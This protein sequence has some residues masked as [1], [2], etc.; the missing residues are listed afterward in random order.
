MLNIFKNQFKILL[1][2]KSL[3]F[4]S[5]IFPLILGTLF[6]LAFSNMEE[7]EKFSKI[8]IAVV[9][10]GSFLD[11]VNS[12][13]D[14][15][16]VKEVSKEEAEEMLLDNDITGYYE[17]K[18]EI[19]IYV[20]G[21][22]TSST[23]M[24]Y[25]VDNYYVYSSVGMSVYENTG[26]LISGIESNNYF[27]DSSNDKVDFTVI[28]FYTLIGM[29]C[30]LAGSFGIYAVTLSEANLS[31]KGARLSVSPTNKLKALLITLITV[32]IVQYIEILIIYFY[33]IVILGIKFSYI[34]H[35]L[36]LTLV[37]CIAG[38]S[39]GAFIGVSN[40]KDENGKNGILTAV[41]MTASFLS[42]MMSFQV[43]HL[44]E[45]SMPLLAKINPV[46]M[47][48]DGLLSLYYAN[49]DRF[50]YNLYSLV[51]FSLIFIS[52]SY[53]FIRRKK[54]DSI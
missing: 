43:K 42:G 34:Y 47:I 11:V 9:G 13:D 53:F 10:D 22:S 1:R 51:L 36:L 26:K 5:L 32:F 20:K 54:Y 45:T 37:G 50:Y 19:E 27:I 14:V 3:I 40:K 6:H 38:I 33:L 39:L 4:W 35:M 23:I 15:F 18:D 2:S 44:V 28:F 46:N 49:L 48:T 12:L 25:V 7:A 52:A 29:V 17:I 30:M 31:K 24:K 21:N 16:T 8:E 41:V